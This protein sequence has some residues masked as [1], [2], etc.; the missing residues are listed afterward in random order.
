VKPQDGSAAEK[1]VANDGED[2][3]AVAG[4]RVGCR[5]RRLDD[6]GRLSVIWRGW[7]TDMRRF[8]DK[9][10]TLEKGQEGIIR[11]E[12]FEDF[13]PGDFI[14]TLA[15]SRGKEDYDDGDARR[16]SRVLDDDGEFE[17]DEDEEE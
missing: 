3:E 12:D 7:C 4:R 11:L 9:V 2:D 17:Y 8:K 16:F 6:E 15:H 14:E 13:Q 5:V 10:M 1:D